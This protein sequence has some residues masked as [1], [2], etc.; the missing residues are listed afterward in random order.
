VTQTVGRALGVKEDLSEFYAMAA[1]D[2]ILQD[3]VKDLYGMRTVFWPELFPALILATTLKMAP[4]KRS[5]QMMDL[6]ITNYGTKSVST[7][8]PSRI[9]PHPRR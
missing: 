7:A 6:L 1:N 8:K 4:M 3:V 5:N 9:G 2:Q